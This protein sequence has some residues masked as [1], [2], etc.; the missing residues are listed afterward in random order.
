MSKPWW[1]QPTV[2]CTARNGLTLSLWVGTLPT[3]IYAVV[4]L[5][6]LGRNKTMTQ[7]P[8][9]QPDEILELGIFAKTF[10]GTS[11]DGVFEAIAQH[12][13]SCTQWNWACVPGLTSS[14]LRW[15]G[16][17][18]MFLTEKANSPLSAC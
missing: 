9:L 12:G 14:N 6:P 18:S 7:S 15:A 4:S 2:R 13:L 11:I 10:Q 17:L 3:H 1:P 8:F 16:E 5:P